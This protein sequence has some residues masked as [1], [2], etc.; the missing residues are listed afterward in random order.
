[1]KL[2]SGEKFNL[3]TQLCPQY[4]F[5]YFDS[6]GKCGWGA[7]NRL[8]SFHQYTLCSLLRFSYY[9]SLHSTLFFFRF[10]PRQYFLVCRFSMENK[11]SQDDFF[12]PA[13]RQSRTQKSFHAFYFSLFFVTTLKFVVFYVNQT[14]II[15]KKWSKH[16]YIWEL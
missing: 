9:S 4:I 8:N 1:M 11:F 7:C 5:L 6:V 15:K 16:R 14:L 12:F 13:M 3:F 10:N 2:Q